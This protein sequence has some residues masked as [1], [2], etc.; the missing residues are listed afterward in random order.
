[1]TSELIIDS[2]A[3]GGGASVLLRKPRSCAEVYNDLN[4]DV[5]N[6]FRVLRDDDQADRLKNQLELTPFSRTEFLN[7]Y[8]PAANPVESARRFVVRC[9]MG[10]GTSGSR[11]SKTGF[12]AR[13]LR[14]GGKQSGVTDFVTYPEAIAAFSERLRGV[15]IECRTALELIALHDAPDTLFYVDPPYVLSTR[16]ILTG[17]GNALRPRNDRLRTFGVVQGAPCGGRNGRGIGIR[18]RSLP[19]S[20]PGMD[21]ADT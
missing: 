8:E 14:P 11:T 15:I 2:F 20:I 16:T 7:A 6:L 17:G 19:G 3:G 21:D 12:R 1:M 5:V 9:C 4:A 13:P 18:L 10:F